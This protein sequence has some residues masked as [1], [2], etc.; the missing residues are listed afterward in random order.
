MGKVPIPQCLQSLWL[1]GGVI[2]N[3]RDFGSRIPGSNPGRVAL[4]R[5]RIARIFGT[6]FLTPVFFFPL[7]LRLANF[8][9]LNLYGVRS[10][11]L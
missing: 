8:V 7:G 11:V 4:A 10:G 9:C 3:T 6:R 2:G 5:R 1:P